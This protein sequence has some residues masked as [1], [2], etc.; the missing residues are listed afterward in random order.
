MTVAKGIGSNVETLGG[1]TKPT[2]ST[3]FINN[4]MSGAPHSNDA[5]QPVNEIRKRTPVAWIV[6]GLFG[7]NAQ[8]GSTCKPVGGL[9]MASP[10][11][12]TS[13]NPDHCWLV[14]TPPNCVSGAIR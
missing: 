10:D 2:P 9:F 4:T 13:T 8:K 14:V 7:K 1:V 5:A 3:N 12:I 11:T 6:S